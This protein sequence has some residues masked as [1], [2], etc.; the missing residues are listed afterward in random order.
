MQSLNPTV[1][2][3][4]GVVLLIKEVGLS[5]LLEFDQYLNKIMIPTN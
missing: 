1:E 5:R 4:L 3:Y 2:D